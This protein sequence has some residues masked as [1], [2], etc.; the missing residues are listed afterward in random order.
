MISVV[1]GG[2]STGRS[3]WCPSTR[4]RPQSH[5]SESICKESLSMPWKDTLSPEQ[6]V[7]AGHIGSHARLLAGPGTGKTRTLTRRVLALVL[8]HE[9]QPSQIL[10][11]T[12]TRMAASELRREIREILKPRALEIPRVSTL[13]SFALRQLLR[14]EARIGAL[15]KPLRI[16]DDWEERHIIEED[17]KDRLHKER[18]KDIQ[19]LFEQ[20]SADWET[21]NRDHAD[22]EELFSD[23]AFI[24]AWR[25]HRTVFG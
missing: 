8:E 16:A 3:G 24:G 14:N 19:D 2:E 20:L 12:F 5:A 23:P 22:W 13:H 6:I 17:L 15:P 21:L 25:E 7:A 9:V 4:N 18:I 1:R 10:A 11:L